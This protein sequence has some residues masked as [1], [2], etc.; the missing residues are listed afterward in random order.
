LLVDIAEG[1]GLFGS[2]NQSGHQN[3]ASNNLTEQIAS[4][5]KWEKRIYVKSSIGVDITTKVK[6]I[7]RLE[8]P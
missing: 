2:R 7:N 8:F 5:M 4:A 1:I 3:L 6:S